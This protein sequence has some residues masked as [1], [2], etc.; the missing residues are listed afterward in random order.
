MNISLFLIR[1]ET[2]YK[3][4][5]ISI[6][7]ISLH[8]YKLNNRSIRRPIPD[9]NQ[10]NSPLL[11]QIEFKTETLENKKKKK[12]KKKKSKKKKKKKEEERKKEFQLSFV[13]NIFKP[14]CGVLLFYLLSTV[15]AFWRVPI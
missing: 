8:L 2:F 1:F 9:K 11:S 3:K 7:L 5:G 12:K 4:N 14:E 6:K 10:I 15:L 13:L